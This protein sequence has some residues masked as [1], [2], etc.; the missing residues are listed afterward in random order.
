MTTENW[1]ERHALEQAAAWEKLAGTW[2]SEVS[3]EAEIE[4][5]YAARTAGR[6]TNL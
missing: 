1:D 5:M 4:A 6:E 2:E 3:V